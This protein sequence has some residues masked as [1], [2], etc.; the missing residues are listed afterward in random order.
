MS[1]Q[2]ISRGA[3]VSKDSAKWSEGVSDDEARELIKGYLASVS[4][5]DAQVGRV[6]AALEASGQANNTIVI[7]WGD[8]GWKLGEHDVWCK[9]ST[10]ENDTNAPHAAGTCR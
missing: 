9:H 10:S 1:L 5:S 7:L 2:A 8:H 4:Y 6:L 3:G